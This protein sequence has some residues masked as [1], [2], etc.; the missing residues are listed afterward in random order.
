MGL[1]STTGERVASGLIWRFGSLEY[2]SD[3]AGCFT[4]RP[5]PAGGSVISFGEHDIYV[6]AVAPPRYP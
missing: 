2:V 3:N 6:A 5:F 1:T 4:N